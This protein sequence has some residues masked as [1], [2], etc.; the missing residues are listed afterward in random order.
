[1]NIKNK[2]KARKFYINLVCII[3][4]SINLKKTKIV[5]LII[6]Q[7]MARQ[8]QI[9]LS[10]KKEKSNQN[11]GHTYIYGKLAIKEI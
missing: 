6:Q 3:L 10:N 5:L 11:L 2:C 8:G 1:M 9:W 7:K 4:V